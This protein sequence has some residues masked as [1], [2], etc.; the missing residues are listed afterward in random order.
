MDEAYKYCE[1]LV[2]EK[3]RELFLA[4]LFAPADRRPHLF[5]LYAFN[6]EIAHIPE[7]V[8]EPMAGEIRLQ[9]W[10]EALSGE[11]EGEAL[12]NPV[13]NAL[14]DTINR[15]DLSK[16]DLASVIDARQFDLLGAPIAS[17]EALEKYLDEISGAPLKL[18]GCI[19]AP[20]NDHSSRLAS[21]ARAHGLLRILRNLSRDISRGRLLVPL[22][23][24]ASDEVHTASV[25]A[26]EMSDGL[27]GALAE[28]RRWTKDNLAEFR[29]ESVPARLLPAVLPLALAKPYLAQMEEPGYDPFRKPSELSALRSQFTLWRAA[30]TGTI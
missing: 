30:R 14:L 10:R 3:D 22:D 23:L 17:R 13:A 26:G 24:L 25:M 8:R 20:E 27:R 12:A 19:L 28:M 18:A 16:A 2:R 4:T 1:A 7:A 21:A 9:W 5:A 15:R 6:L 11:R 29:K